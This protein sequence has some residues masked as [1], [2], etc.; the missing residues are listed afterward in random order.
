MSF[1]LIAE[2]IGFVAFL[3]LLF[4]S[5]S[6]TREKI[7]FN[8]LISSLIFIIHFGLL[9]AWT[10]VVMN[11]LIVFRNYIFIKKPKYA[12]AQ[13]I[14]WLFLFIF[15]TLTLTALSWEGYISILPAFAVAAGTYGRWLSR[16]FTIRFISLFFGV[17]LW[18]PY[19]ILVGSYSGTAAQIAIGIAIVYGMFKHDSLKET[20]LKNKIAP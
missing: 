20:L 19:T 14:G 18:L 12:W 4:S 3:F 16:P 8:Q 10:G 1:S 5:Q 9:S 2:A 7:L 17:L 11:L 15:L 13:H 6:K